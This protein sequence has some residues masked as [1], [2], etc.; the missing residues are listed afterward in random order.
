MPS[1]AEGFKQAFLGFGVYG[2]TIWRSGFV[3]P[4]IK[5]VYEPMRAAVRALM[6]KGYTEKEAYT[7]VTAWARHA[8][9]TLNA[10]ARGVRIF[11]EKCVRTTPY[12]ALPPVHP[13]WYVVATVTALAG[14]ALLLYVWVILD[15]EFGVWHT[16]HEWA[17][18]M[19]YQGRLWQGE[20]YAVEWADIGIY[21]RG[22][23]LGEVIAGQTRDLRGEKGRDFLTFTPGEVYLGGRRLLFYHFYRFLG[24]EVQ[25]LGLL[26][27]IAHGF[28]KLRK[29]GSDPY[30]PVGPWL[31]PGGLRGTKEYEGCWRGWWG[32]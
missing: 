11:V 25:F 2:G 26:T 20:L 8:H 5:T 19:T 7:A 14:I 32:L 28:Y 31:R 16:A 22:V 18:A 29:G 1:E 23:D 9:Q 24:W 30:R 15:K 4:A 6:T 17:Y 10:S 21:E 12:K 3:D 27:Q 13:W